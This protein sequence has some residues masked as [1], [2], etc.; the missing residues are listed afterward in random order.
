MNRNEMAAEHIEDELHNAAR[1]I[2]GEVNVMLYACEQAMIDKVLEIINT[3][4]TYKMFEGQEDTYI[5][6]R[7]L[8]EAVLAL[9]R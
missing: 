3:A 1:N 4:Q 6:K 9:R 8:R 7:V 2:A 5:D